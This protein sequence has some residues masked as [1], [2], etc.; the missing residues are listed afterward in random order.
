MNLFK[1][2]SN[3]L[4]VGGE[5][6]I[7][8][9]F[10]QKQQNKT[11]T[12]M[13]LLHFSPK[14]SQWSFKL[15]SQDISV[16]DN[17][18]LYFSKSNVKWSQFNSFLSSGMKNTAYKSFTSIIFSCLISANDCS[19]SLT[20]VYSLKLVIAVLINSIFQKVFFHKTLSLFSSQHRTHQCYHI[21]II[22]FQL[23][24]KKYHLSMLTAKTIIK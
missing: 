1:C 22:F 13:F 18:S 12:Q 4:G 8:A 19:F 2:C 20:G 11:H 3:C 10:N 15:L 24:I 23:L 17:G 5:T 14:I 21:T 9:G 6:I 16:L 7:N